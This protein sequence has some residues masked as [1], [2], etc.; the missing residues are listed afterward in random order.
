MADAP[1]QPPR[2]SGLSD[3][4]QMHPLLNDKHPGL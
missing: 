4:Q 2:Y 3:V 1:N